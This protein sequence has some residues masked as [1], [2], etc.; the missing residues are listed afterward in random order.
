MFAQEQTELAISAVFVMFLPGS[1]ECFLNDLA[2]LQIDPKAVVGLVPWEVAWVV[3]L[4]AFW[5]VV[6]E[7]R[8]WKGF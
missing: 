1:H 2:E 7:W 6:L 5:G 4:G 3:A 8:F